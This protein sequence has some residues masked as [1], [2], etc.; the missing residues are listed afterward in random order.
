MAAA[1][2]GVVLHHPAVRPELGPEHLVELGLGAQAMGAGG[3]E[4]GHARWQRA[5]QFV[6]Q[7]GQHATGGERARDV[8]DDDGDPRAARHAVQQWNTGRGPA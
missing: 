3:D 7:N 2:E 5:V 4:E 8:A 6:Q 1:V